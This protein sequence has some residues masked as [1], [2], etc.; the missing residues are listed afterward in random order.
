MFNWFHILIYLVIAIMSG[1]AGAVIHKLL[2]IAQINQ[3]LED[4]RTTYA[5]GNIATKRESATKMDVMKRVL[6]LL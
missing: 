1:T 3:L 5:N 4:E 6:E 2:T